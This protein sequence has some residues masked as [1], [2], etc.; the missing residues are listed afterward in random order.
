MS[1]GQWYAV[2]TQPRAESKALSH[3]LRQGYETYLP[4]YLR[5]RRHARKVD[6]VPAPLFPRYLFVRLDLTT[7]PWRS[8][9]STV[10][11]SQ[12]VCQ[13]DSPAQVAPGVVE[14]LK[15][16]EIS[17]FIKFVSPLRFSRGDKVRLLD[18]VF[19]TCIGLFEGMTDEE[20]IVV[21]L[22][23][24]GRKVRV[25]IEMESVAAA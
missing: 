17:G 18:G 2:Q 11:V 20:R 15:D 4:Q 21:L 13:G 25:S 1:T 5:R 19:S 8:I 3:L 6:T 9:R 10:G 12:V 22:E 23:L 14:A 16:R 7:Q 24:L